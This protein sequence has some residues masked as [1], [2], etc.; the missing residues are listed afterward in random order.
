MIFI[1]LIISMLFSAAA[2]AAPEDVTLIPL[3]RYYPN[4]Q[5]YGFYDMCGESSWLGMVFHN[6]GTQS[7][8][9]TFPS[10]VRIGGVNGTRHPIDNLRYREVPQNITNFIGIP[11]EGTA[12]STTLT[13]PSNK[14]YAV[15]FDIH[16][17]EHY[18]AQWDTDVFFSVVI[19]SAGSSAEKSI[20]GP[21]S[22][23][24]NSSC[25]P[26][27]VCKAT[28][29]GGSY[30]ADGNGTVTVNVKN[31]M[32]M[33]AQ[34]EGKGDVSVTWT[35]PSGAKQTKNLENAVTWNQ[36]P[37]WMAS[38]ENKT[39]TGTFRLPAE[40]TSGSNALTL[41]FHFWHPSS[42]F[43]GDFY[44]QGKLFSTSGL[45]GTVSGN[46]DTNG[47]NGVFKAVI[48]NSQNKAVSIT[49]PQEGKVIDA[50]GKSSTVTLAWKNA[51]P[52]SIT[53]QG[54][55]AL[56]GTFIF[57]DTG[58]IHNNS[59]L[60]LSIN[61]TAEDSTGTAAGT[62]TRNPDPNPT[63]KAT[64]D[65]CRD[66]TAGSS[67]MSFSYSIKSE[68]SIDLQVEL[69]TT[70]H[71]SGQTANPK[72]T[73]TGCQN[74]GVSCINKITKGIY[75]IGPGET[76]TFSGKVS[77]VNPY[78]AADAFA[79]T[80]LRYFA[81]SESRVVYI[82]KTTNSCSVQPSPATPEPPKIDL[83][84][85]GL[86]KIYTKGSNKIGFQYTL[87]N[88]SGN[89]IPVELADTLGVEGQSDTVVI[90]YTA[91]KAGAEFCMD[92]I[93]NGKEFELKAGETATFTG[94]STLKAIPAGEDFSIRTSLLYFP[95]GER[96]ALFVG[97][98][99][100]SCTGTPVD[101]DPVTPDLTT[102]QFCRSY[103]GGNKL[104]FRYSL[105]NNTKTDIVLQLAKTMAV[106]GQTENASIKYTGCTI[107]GENCAIT[108]EKFTIQAG[109]TVVFSGNAV[110]KEA[111]SKTDFY[112]YTSL[113]YTI[114]GTSKV[115]STGR[116][117]SSEGC[118]AVPVD[119]MPTDLTITSN[120]FYRT[121]D[122][123]NGK[124]IFTYTLV[125]NNDVAI[126]VD[127]ART[128]AVDG[129]DRTLPV[130]YTACID[131]NGNDCIKKINDF[132]FTLSAKDTADFTGEISLAKA[133]VNT[134][135]WIYT[136]LVYT[137]NG[138]Q[139]ILDL[140]KTQT[141]IP[142]GE[143][144]PE[145]PV[146]DLTASGL[147]R[148]Y[149]KGSN[150][151]LVRYTLKNDSESEI[152][153][154]LA[155]T[156][157]VEGQSSN[158]RITYT[159]CKIGVNSCYNRITNQ[160]EITLAPGEEAVFTGKA[161]LNT[162]PQNTEF[163][164]HTSLIYYADK[165]R[166]ALFIGES[167][168][169]CT[170]VQPGDE[171]AKA[172]LIRV[173]FCRTD[174]GN[175]KVAIQYGLKNNTG[176]DIVLQLAKTLAVKGLPGTWPIRYISCT[177]AS[178]RTCSITGENF[179]LKAGETI[180]F[181]GEV[182]VSGKL[183]STDF[184][185]ST[186]L[187]YTIDGTTKSYY[188][189]ETG[190]KCGAIPVVPVATDLVITSEGF[191]RD[192]SADK[193][194]VTFTYTLKNETGINIPVELAKTL[195]ADGQSR[196]LPIT[197]TKC[198]SNNAGICTGRINGYNIILQAGETAAFSGEAILEKAVIN[199]DF[200]VYTS[201]LYTPNSI[202][203]ILDLGQTA[204]NCQSGAAN[205]PQNPV[206]QS[207]AAAN[208]ELFTP[209]GYYSICGSDNALHFTMKI[210]NS[211]TKTG[212][213]DL[214]SMR[215]ALNGNDI[216]ASSISFDSCAESSVSGTNTMRCTKELPTG[217]IS[218]DPDVT[219][220]ISVSYRPA[221]TISGNSVNVSV[222]AAGMTPSSTS[223]TASAA[224]SACS[225]RVEAVT[226]NN[227]E[228]VHTNVSALKNV[229]TLTMQFVNTGNEGAV[230]TPASIKLHQKVIENYEGTLDISPISGQTTGK[231]LM[232]LTS[233]TPF[234]LPA[235]S[236]A[237]LSV[238]LNV[239]MSEAFTSK[240]M[241][242]WTIKIDNSTKNYT[243][244]VNFAQSNPTPEIN[245]IVPS[246]NDR[247]SFFALGEPQ[248]PE[249]LPATGFPTHGQHK[250]ASIQPAHL[251]YEELNGLHMEIPVLN[252][253]MDLVRI[254]LDDNNEWAVEWLNDK[255]GILSYSKVP[256][257]GTSIIAGHNHL[258]KMNVGPFL[259]L[260]QL[261]NND[262]IF[263]TDDDGE[264]LMYSV[265]ANEL[266]NPTDSELI[267]QKAIPGS[268]V[269]LTC[270]NEMPEGGY[271]Y[272][273]AVFAEPLQ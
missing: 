248:L 253:G 107:A 144:E 271:A 75:T 158:S 218:I 177:A 190:S 230:I 210:R 80:S 90:T 192:L 100:K 65:F 19:T 247:L 71:V 28:I 83:T 171:T 206:D 33:T 245:P 110:L 52:V 183:P 174:M 172:D 78:P 91:C 14:T 246:G 227:G 146:I 205:Q 62:V 6:N 201:L 119:P 176:S 219:M 197:Y 243:G 265:Y 133:P 101:P 161:V 66:Y 108:G 111:P 55:A 184:V 69:A 1:V 151:I 18:A 259:M 149:T 194:K 82:G 74:G 64:G 145:P 150:N 233:G 30:T 38:G 204:T 224:G 72:I 215:F 15:F 40:I 160:N 99:S 54:S 97:E 237:T 170:A 102:V 34:V 26:D 208:L 42:L 48:Y 122:A 187:V 113:I 131:D 105:Q 137:P 249:K 159:D 156:L 154:E 93:K 11:L 235:L 153:V 269:L 24:G 203:K 216:P 118:S 200:K 202:R 117:V 244:T 185:V 193:S 70:L 179:I 262:R 221:Q 188:I 98:S 56:D 167:K 178:N 45:H 126:P 23:R 169:V 68:A 228:A 130:K 155:T 256:G 220:S 260:W 96:K 81:D 27:Q 168:A 88:E 104:D 37:G 47:R 165:V 115:Y 51:G 4:K 106:E 49:L 254:P 152:P 182:S 17:I 73:Y 3:T 267:Y 211:G 132:A 199:E 213:A 13:L 222:R 242:S 255:A 225:A 231:D 257:E 232:M 87:T 12:F 212:Y 31:N 238:S 57:N 127:L 76:A 35:D 109:K 209:S 120:S 29:L 112:V 273:R 85:D 94:E 58:L 128:I 196:T 223:F 139:K 44:A 264:F 86:C 272:R 175:G 20:N 141:D 123:A 181:N 166:K 8:S 16:K 268:L 217:R 43:F 162:I 258:D 135:F 61:L 143:D 189:G 173:S 240:A 10:E 229:V 5:C 103:D 92:R 125:N 32:P 191:C 89:T 134:D 226:E 77:L 129:Q 195:A 147:C 163:K 250:P 239:D 142:G 46:Y 114:N 251:A 25:S 22:Q 36:N 148:D 39:V 7:A 261:E 207:Q 164:V 84:S 136:S 186:S 266:I 263:I 124:V 53:A 21:I 252:K 121:Y 241:I 60:I 50:S 138:I 116:S 67:E 214:S 198:V 41:A 140:G 2:N 79:E 234:T 270:E 9:I 63:L 236:A 95:N 157:A 59:S 180:Y